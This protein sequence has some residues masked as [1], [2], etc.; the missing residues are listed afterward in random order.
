MKYGWNADV[1]S[2]KTITWGLFALVAVVACVFAFAS[3]SIFLGAAL[4]AFAGYSVYK[5]N[6]KFDE[7]FED[8]K[9]FRDKMSARTQDTKEYSNVP[10]VPSPQKNWQQDIV[11]KPSGNDKGI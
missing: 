1:E 5:A 9:R 7:L 11:K 6:H 4:V 10:E 8:N 3:G 2:S